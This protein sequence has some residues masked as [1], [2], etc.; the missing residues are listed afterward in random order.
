MALPLPTHSKFQGLGLADG[1]VIRQAIVQ[2]QYLH[3]KSVR[4]IIDE[5]T[6]L[7]LDCD[8]VHCIYSGHGR[9]DGWFR[10][11]YNPFVLVEPAG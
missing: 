8:A 1:L 7:I 3:G 4:V 6:G 2:G 9:F 5:A 11:E 10:E